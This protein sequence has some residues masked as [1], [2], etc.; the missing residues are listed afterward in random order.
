MLCVLCTFI[1][2]Y[3]LYRSHMVGRGSS[4]EQGRDRMRKHGLPPRIRALPTIST[5]PASTTP[6]TATISTPPSHPPHTQEFV[7]ISNPGYVEPGP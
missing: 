6:T 1:D 7:M 2:L 4:S 3:T 5:V